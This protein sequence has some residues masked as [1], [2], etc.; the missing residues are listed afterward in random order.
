MKFKILTLL[1]I[2]NAGFCSVL[3]VPTEFSTVSLA[4]SSSSNND[5]I[6]VYDGI[7]DINNIISITHGLLIKGVGEPHF[8]ISIPTTDFAFTSN[9]LGNEWISFQNIIIETGQTNLNSGLFHIDNNLSIIGCKFQSDYK[10]F[11]WFTGDTT[12]IVSSEISGFRALNI[13]SRNLEFSRVKF[14]NIINGLNLG[15]SN[16]TFCDIGDCIFSNIYNHLNFYSIGGEFSQITNCLFYGIQSSYADYSFSFNG[17]WN[18]SNSIVWNCSYDSVYGCLMRANPWGACSVVFEYSC[19]Q[20]G[21]SGLRDAIALGTGC[22]ASNP[23][24]APNFRLNLSSPCIDAGDPNS[25]HDP[26]GTRAD[27]G[28]YY[29]CQGEGIRLPEIARVSA[30]PGYP[31][32]LT[33]TLQSTCEA[34][35]IDTAYTDTGLFQ[36][37]PNYPNQVASDFCTGNFHLTFAPLQ[38]GLYADTLHILADTDPPHLKIPLV[39]EAGPIPAPVADLAIAILPDLSAQ[40]TWSPVTETIYGNPVTPDYYLIFYNELDPQVEEEWYYQGAVAT[41]GYLHFMVARFADVMNYRVVAWKG[42]D[43]ALLGWKTG[44]K[45]SVVSLFANTTKD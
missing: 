20:D 8:L 1:L 29:F 6:E 31:E 14:S 25:P 13:F 45:M 23:N 36:L 35:A 42:I 40:L 34:V 10:V 33:T 43:P 26:D 38:Q 9:F 2:L 18:T 15:T 28:A 30:E 16:T 21:S 19:V 41:P 22:F 24:L 5:T 44:M 7:Y 37:A 11:G 3:R 12:K 4:I 17:N 27:I 32:A 39:G